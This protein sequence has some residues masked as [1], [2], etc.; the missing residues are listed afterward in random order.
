VSAQLG[1]IVVPPSGAEPPYRFG[2]T[3]DWYANEQR[4]D[5]KEAGRLEKE[6][7]DPLSIIRATSY[8]SEGIEF[9]IRRS[10]FPGQR[11]LMRI[12]ASVLTGD[13]PGWIDHP[14]DGWL[15]L[16]FH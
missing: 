3:T 8:P 2:L 15:E 6:G 9:A 12:G 14:K 16:H 7:K 11:W 4:R 1:E 13:K 5:M 10:K